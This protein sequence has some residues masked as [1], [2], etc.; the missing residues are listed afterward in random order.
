MA[1]NDFLQHFMVSNGFELSI[2]PSK[3]SRPTMIVKLG[4]RFMVFGVITSRSK[5]DQIMI[6]TP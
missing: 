2:L 6:S 3:S 1:I 4:Y 5:V